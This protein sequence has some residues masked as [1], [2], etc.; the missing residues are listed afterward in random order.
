MKKLAIIFTAIA[1]L[2]GCQ[3]EET[4]Y[5]LLDTV[6]YN[7]YPE[8]IFGNTLN[9]YEDP[10]IIIYEYCQS[11]V[12]EEVIIDPVPYREK[13]YFKPN[14]KTEYISVCYK[15]HGWWEKMQRDEPQ[16]RYE[17]KVYY[18]KKNQDTPIVI[19]SSTSVSG[20]NPVK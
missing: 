18:I 12:V 8:K 1:V 7:L 5:S 20:K 2:A 13:M 10:Y 11:N 15:S 4:S 17:T 9:N 16:T 19:N 14:E 3:K 6:N